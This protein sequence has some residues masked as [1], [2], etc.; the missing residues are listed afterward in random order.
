MSNRFNPT[1]YIK[2]T[3]KHIFKE[4]YYMSY[5]MTPLHDE[6]ICT[7]TEMKQQTPTKNQTLMRRTPK[8]SVF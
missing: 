8:T 7:Q 2:Y 5:V 1:N 6:T 3:S 4:F